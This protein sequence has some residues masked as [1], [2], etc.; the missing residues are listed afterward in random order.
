MSVRVP[1][2]LWSGLP[3]AGTRLVP[4]LYRGVQGGFLQ[5]ERY[6]KGNLAGKLAPVVGHELL[7]GIGDI[8]GA[9]G[10][11]AVPEG[12]RDVQAVG[13]GRALGRGKQVEH[14]RLGGIDRRGRGTGPGRHGRGRGRRGR[15]GE[16]YGAGVGRVMRAAGEEH[17]GGNAL[18]YARQGLHDTGGVG[19]ETYPDRPGK[20]RRSYRGGKGCT[21]GTPA[22]GW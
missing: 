6:R 20:L 14:L 13:T 7:E 1:L 22:A 5:V 2:C 4:R 11:G 15:R 12:Q 18:E 16:L 21:Q 10:L 19:L 9:R 8:E 3:A 17:S